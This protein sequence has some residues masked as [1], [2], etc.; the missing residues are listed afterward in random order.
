MDLTFA[1]KAGAV[2]AGSDSSEHAQ[3]LFAILRARLTKYHDVLGGEG[4]R[5]E[6]KDLLGIQLDTAIESLRVIERVH[7]ILGGIEDPGGAERAAPGDG[8]A[9]EGGQDEGIPAV[10]TR[11]MALLR[12]LLSI[13]FKWGTE[14][15]LARLIASFP[16]KASHHGPMIIDLTSAPGDYALLSSLLSRLLTL[17]FPLGIHGRL[18]QTFV[19]STILNRHVTDVLRPC[20]VFAWLP[21]DLKSGFSPSEDLK[22]LALR[23]LSACAYLYLPHRPLALL[24]RPPAASRPRKRSRPSVRS[25][26]PPRSR[27]TRAKP[28]QVSSAANCYART[29]SP[30]SSPRSSAKPTPTPT[31]RW[32][33]SRT[34]RAC[35][36]PRPQVCLARCVG[37]FC[38][39]GR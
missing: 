33:S 11:D 28:A 36:A 15:L 30:A 5:A 6:E 23:L 3:D 32:R 19:T 1:L 18:S 9:R 20:I 25:S 29:A 2:L 24:T 39:S 13:A 17:L 21:N 10:G 31:R 35:S 26:P 8:P 4:Q 22:P 37:F 14:P 34:S 7:I 38:S 12:T 27:H 16:S